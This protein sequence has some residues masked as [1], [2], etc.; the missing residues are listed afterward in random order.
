MNHVINI[1]ILAV[2]LV[3]AGTL[4]AGCAQMSRLI[5]TKTGPSIMAVSTES[6]VS[7][8]VLPTMRVVTPV[9]QPHS[10]EITVDVSSAQAGALIEPLALR[11]V[12]PRP[13]TLP[14]RPSNRHVA[15]ELTVLTPEYGVEDLPFIE[16][17]DVEMICESTKSSN[18]S[19]EPTQDLTTA[20][21]AVITEHT[22]EYYNIADRTRTLEKMIDDELRRAPDNRMYPGS[23][24]TRYCKVAIGDRIWM[25]VGEWGE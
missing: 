4:I 5:Q 3:I 6:P 11:R 9:E 16:S 19:P 2:L 12:K 17:R 18:T 7:P 10:D 25:D 24:D 20:D 15:T 1:A 22:T 8:S 21:L 13:D 14:D 23:I